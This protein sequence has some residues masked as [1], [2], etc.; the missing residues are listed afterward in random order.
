MNV[1]VTI[2]N[3]PITGLKRKVKVKEFYVNLSSVTLSTET[4]FFDD[5]DN[6]IESKSVKPFN[7][8]LIAVNSTLVNPNNG[9]TVEDGEDAE[10]C[11]MGEYDYLVMVANNPINIFD[12][13]EAT[14]LK[15]DT[16]N[17]FD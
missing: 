1:E 6:E 8:Q 11:T 3:D 2:S 16:R 13:M 5:Q 10:D 4:K 14:I 12:I 17:R 9:N 15:A 7:V